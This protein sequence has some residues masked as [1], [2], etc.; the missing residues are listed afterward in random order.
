MEEE[1]EVD[2]DEMGQ[3]HHTNQSNVGELIYFLLGYTLKIICTLDFLLLWKI[4]YG[5]KYVSKN[6]DLRM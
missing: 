6:R 3:T 4:K 5:W 1:E 2:E